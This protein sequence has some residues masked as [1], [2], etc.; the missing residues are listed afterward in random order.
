[1]S[2]NRSCE[3]RL[4][5]DIGR[6]FCFGDNTARLEIYEKPWHESVPFMRNC[7]CNSTSNSSHLPLIYTSTSREIELHFSAFNMSNYDDPDTLNF[8]ATFEFF[9]ST[10]TCKDNRKRAGTEGDVVLSAGEVSDFLIEMDV[11]P[12]MLLKL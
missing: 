6:S 5:R 12:L 11:K 3:S 9:K 2:G 7:I 8:E 10:Q 1:M 4:D